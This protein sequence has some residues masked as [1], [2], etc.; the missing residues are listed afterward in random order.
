MGWVGNY[1]FEDPFHPFAQAVLRAL[2]CSPAAID[3]ERGQQTALAVRGFRRAYNRDAW[4][5]DVRPR[6]Y[7]DLPDGDA[8]DEPT[9]KALLDAYHAEYSGRLDPARF[10]GP[11]HAGCGEFNPRGSKNADNRRVTLVVYGD[12]AP[13]PLDFPCRK[14]DAGACKIDGGAGSKAHFTCKFYR[15]HVDETDVD[16]ELTP[17]W[18]LVWLRTHTGKAHLSALTHLPDTNDATFVVSVAPG[19]GQP[20]DDSGMDGA[21][22]DVG[23]VVAKLPGLI[24]RGVAYALWDAGSDYDPFDQRHWF[25]LPSET[26]APAWLAP[27]M[28]PIFTIVSGTQWG[29]SEGPGFDLPKVR[30]SQAPPGAVLALRASGRLVL[31]PGH[32]S[33]PTAERARTTALFTA[34]REVLLAE[35]DTHE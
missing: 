25:R 20:S 4:H 28:P 11:Q 14:N 26:R 9:R 1:H 3:G 17:F 5:A 19:G 24:R 34:G 31:V 27:Y 12:D 35:D 16:H 23:V 30:F 21:P 15:D 29:I 7:A 10:L 6:A 33:L 22:P 2:G 18:D 8:L 13:A 32:Q